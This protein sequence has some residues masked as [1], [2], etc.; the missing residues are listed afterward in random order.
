MIPA[1]L[2]G[3]HRA[4]GSGSRKLVTI[5]EMRE[6]TFCDTVA[7]VLSWRPNPHAH[8]RSGDLYLADWT[9]NDQLYA[10]EAVTARANGNWPVGQ[11]ALQVTVYGQEMEP[12]E[13]WETEQVA[14]RM[15]YVKN[16]GPRRNPHGLLEGRVSEKGQRPGDQRLIRFLKDGEFQAERRAVVDR[17]VASRSGQQ[18]QPGVVGA[19]P[20][21]AEEPSDEKVEA[22]AGQRQAERVGRA[23]QAAEISVPV[24]QPPPL[25]MLVAS[26]AAK[27]DNDLNPAAS[28]PPTPPPD[29]VLSTPHEVYLPPPFPPPP[30]ASTPTPDSAPTQ[31]LFNALAGAPLVPVSLALTGCTRGAEFRV[32]ARIVDFAPP[33]LRDWVLAQCTACGTVSVISFLL[34]L[35]SPRCR[36]GTVADR[37]SCRVNPVCLPPPLPASSTPT[38][39][40]PRRSRS[41]LFSPC[42]ARPNRGCSTYR[43]RRRNGC[44]STPRAGR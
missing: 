10:F 27:Q 28:T 33:Q 11:R 18:A 12:F 41:S 42:R 21:A 1:Q 8:P 16:L 23:A 20:D 9:E 26:V 24:A 14:G 22:E 13:G 32:Q 37:V 19:A 43:P 5:S 38:T 29:Q 2:G 15:V 35:S 36:L 39:P 44:S 7:M 25:P 34:T 4:K 31:R 17:L 30:P 3:T 6:G 40:P